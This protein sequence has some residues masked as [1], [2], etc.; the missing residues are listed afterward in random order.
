MTQAEDGWEKPGIAVLALFSSLKAHQALEKAWQE[1]EE[2]GI[3][4]WGVLL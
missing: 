2:I 3:E 4:Q 1:G